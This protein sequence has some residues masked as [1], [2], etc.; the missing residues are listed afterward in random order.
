MGTGGAMVVD[1]ANAEMLLSGRGEMGRVRRN[2]VFR[3]DN[4]FGVGKHGKALNVAVV[5]T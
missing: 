2:N 4:T 1:I 5:H 3:Q